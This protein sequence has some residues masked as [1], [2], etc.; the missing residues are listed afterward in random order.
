MRRLLCQGF[1]SFKLACSLHIDLGNGSN[2]LVITTRKWHSPGIASAFSLIEMVVV[3]AI[4][5]ILLGGV[6]LIYGSGGRVRKSGA[7]AMAGMIEQARTAAIHSRSHVVLAVAEPGDLP[8]G[9]ERCRLG[10]FRVG[11]WPD[12]PEDLS[13]G[14]LM[15]RWRTMETGVV[16]IGGEL[17]GLP[18]PLDAPELTI[19]YGGSKDLRVKVHAIAFNPRGRLHYPAGSTP[20]TMRIAEGNYRNGKP[21]PYL[22]SGSTTIAE[23]RLKI[24]RVLG[25]T[26][27][28]DG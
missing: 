1:L 4:L 10:L 6:G 9:D 19:S 24:G 17:D 25:R 28:T 3:M 13:V 5:L 7:D 8:T 15:S 22:R 16:L 2:N 23:N 11:S 21:T 18:N 14:I 27:R 26:Y 20:V 12:S